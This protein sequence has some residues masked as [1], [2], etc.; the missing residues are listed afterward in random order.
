MKRDKICLGTSGW[1]YDDWQ[2]RFYPADVRGAQRLEFYAT[3]FNAVEVNATFYRL[4]TANMIAAWNR[5]MGPTFHLVVKGWR[6]IT[7]QQKL[8]NC[9]ASVAQF[10]ERTRQLERLV[11]MLWQLPPTLA[12][13]VARL[14]TF[15][16]GLPQQVR[17]AVEFRHPSWWDDGV[18]DVLARHAAAFVAVS[19]PELPED[20][21]PTAD[22]L[23]VRFHGKGR[24]LYR[25]DYTDNELGIW[26]AR[27][28][29]SLAGRRLYAFFNNTYAAQAPKNARRFRQLLG[30]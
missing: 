7:H 19:H 11:V 30:E 2:E 20:V 18:A 6:L 24:E 8:A 10:F 28:K 26:A 9:G 14:A 4:P 17:H 27:L 29:P 13:D 15:L 22:F 1:T 21:I 5:R 16:D 3:Q 23:Y 12:K 25:Y